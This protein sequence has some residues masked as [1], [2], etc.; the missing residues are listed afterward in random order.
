MN[1]AVCLHFEVLS[2]LYCGLTGELAPE[3][4]VIG[5]GLDADTIFVEQG[6]A[7]HHLRVTLLADSIEIKALAAGLSVE[8]NGDIA[9]GE[10][11]VVPLP[12]V[13]HVGEMS[14]LWSGQGAAPAGSSG[15][16]RLSIPVLAFVLVG[17]VGIGALSTVLSYYGS[18]GA[19]SANSW[20]DAT[21]EAR[22][23]HDPTDNQTAQAAARDLQKE[24]DRAGLLNVKIGS[25][26]GVVTAEGTVTSASASSWQGIQQLFDHRTKGA[27]TLVNGVVTKEEKAPSAIAL[28]A[29]WRGPSAYVVID[30]EK[31]FVGALLKDGWTV[32]RIE[33]GHVLLRRN[34]RLASL[35]Y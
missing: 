26:K 33:D 25:A 12:V 27:L 10:C 32:D 11:A 8:G 16:P 24:V 34:G 13:I 6:L 4:N 21:V 19:S 5:S 1:D 22:G 30:G 20:P 17:S 2:G 29:V 31:Y 18:A 7:P 3:P 28:E 23:P 14:I 15:T 35:R 9:A